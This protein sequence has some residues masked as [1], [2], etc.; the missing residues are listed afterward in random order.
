MSSP[1]GR[2]HAARDVGDGDH[3]RAPVVQLGRGDP[4]DV[5]EPLHDAALLREVPVEPLAGA[6]DAHHDAGAGRLVAEERAADRHR[7]A[8]DDLRHGVALLHRV[9]VHHPRHRLLVRRHVG[10]RDVELRA[11][12]RRELGGEAARDARQLALARGRARCSAR[13][14]SRRRTAGAGARTSRSSTSRAPRTRRGRPPGRSGRRPSSARAPRN[15]G[16]D[17]PGTPSTCR[18]PSSPAA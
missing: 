15:A 5:A 9:R 13:R 18:R 1:C 3:A 7:L 6:L 12:E 17:R 16:R 4:A 2:E 8:G 10:R 14:P 11:D